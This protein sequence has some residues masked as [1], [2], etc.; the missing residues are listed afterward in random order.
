MSRK[1]INK[2]CVTWLSELV[3]NEQKLTTLHYYKKF[4]FKD[5]V[6]EIGDY[7]LISNP[8]SAEPD[9]EDGCDVAKILALYED[10]SND[11][12]FRAKVQWYTN[13]DRLPLSCYNQAEPINFYSREV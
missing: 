3:R 12:P 7:V 2:K 6:G 11:H 5:I 10:S 8:D 1:E 4:Q 9:T 13:H